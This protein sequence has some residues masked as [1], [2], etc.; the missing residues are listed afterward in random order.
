MKWQNAI[1]KKDMEHLRD[2]MS[3][4][5][6]LT[7]FRN[8]RKH[9]KDLAKRREVEEDRICLWCSIIEHTLTSKGW[10]I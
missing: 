3:G 2:T 10:T 6:T 1:S 7:R 4:T 5:P 8:Q 9:Q